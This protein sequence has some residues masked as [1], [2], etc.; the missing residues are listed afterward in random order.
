MDPPLAPTVRTPGCPLAPT[1]DPW[2]GGLGVSLGYSEAWK[3]QNVGLL[4]TPLWDGGPNG[5]VST[6][7]AS[8]PPRDR[9]H[10]KDFFREIDTM[11]CVISEAKRGWWGRGSRPD[12]PDH[13]FQPT[14]VFLFSR[15]RDNIYIIF[16]NITPALQPSGSKGDDDLLAVPLIK[17][18]PTFAFV[19]LG[20]MLLAC[21]APRLFLTRKG[22]I[23]DLCEGATKGEWLRWVPAASTNAR[24]T[25]TF[26]FDPTMSNIVIG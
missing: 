1:R 22:V 24:F 3:L 8:A 12:D 21:S 26:F 5:R 7:V 15:F 20:G 6:I 2:Y 9:A 25:L 23:R 11:E 16:M 13:R 19:H 14:Q 18:E 17:W 10:L 4:V